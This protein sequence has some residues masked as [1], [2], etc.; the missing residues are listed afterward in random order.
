MAVVPQIL[1]GLLQR[2]ADILLG[3]LALALG[4]VGRPVGRGANPVR[5]IVDRGARAVEAVVDLRAGIVDGVA[6]VIA[7]RGAGIFQIVPNL[8]DASIYRMTATYTAVVSKDNII[9]RR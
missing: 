4:I 1:A 9:Y 8:A 7:D 5:A 3:F 2:G 6:D